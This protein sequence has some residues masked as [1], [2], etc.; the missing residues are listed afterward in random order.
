MDK[1]PDDIWQIFPLFNTT[2]VEFF[3]LVPGFNVN[4]HF[5]NLTFNPLLFNE[6]QEEDMIEEDT[7]INSLINKCKY[8]NTDQL[9]YDLKGD[10]DLS[11][12]H[13]NIRIGRERAY[14][15]LENGTE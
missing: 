4:N 2:P 13:I 7:L 1:S 3:D 15:D 9:S 10:T 12:M 5:E 8:V 6:D 11:M 14:I